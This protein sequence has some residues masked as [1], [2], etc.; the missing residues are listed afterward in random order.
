MRSLTGKSYVPA[1]MPSNANILP[2]SVNGNLCG[3]DLYVNEPRISVTIS[4]PSLSATCL[5]ITNLLLDAGSSGLSFESKRAHNKTPV[6]RKRLGNHT[7]IPCTS[8]FLK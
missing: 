6:F 4:S 8:Y 5:T 7:L 2:V 1:L 3:S